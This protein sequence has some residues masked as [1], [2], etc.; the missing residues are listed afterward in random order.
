MKAKLILTILMTTIF[1]VGG[2]YLFVNTNNNYQTSAPRESTNP[3]GI[4]VGEANPSA[5]ADSKIYTLAQISAHKSESSC[6]TAING[7]V[8]DLTQW[9][10]E[11]PGGQE[12]I[13]VICGIDGSSAFNN[14]HGGQRRPENI[15][16]RFLIGTLIK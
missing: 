9:I 6:W 10:N 3:K 1:V 5:P 12:N 7:N 11:H 14:Q 8:Y 2:F 4:A 15:L 16:N 13:L